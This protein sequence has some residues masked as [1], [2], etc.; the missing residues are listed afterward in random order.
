MSLNQ[1]SIPF[2][3]LKAADHEISASFRRVNIFFTSPSEIFSVHCHK[4]KTC[5]KKINYM[6]EKNLKI[7]RLTEVL[8]DLLDKNSR[9]F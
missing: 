4:I 2:S 8:E 9:L 1:S 6:G 7:K 5:A 3:L